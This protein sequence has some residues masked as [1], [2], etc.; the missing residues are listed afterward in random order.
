MAAKRM[1][2][3]MDDVKDLAYERIPDNEK[4]TSFDQK[5]WVIEAIHAFVETV[6]M[7]RDLK[8]C[9]VKNDTDFPFI[10]SDDPAILLNRFYSQ[11]LG[12]RW[13]SF[14]VN[15]AGVMLMLPLSPVLLM[16]SYD[17]NIYTCPDIGG[18][19]VKVDKPSDVAAIN[20]LQYLKASKNLYFSNWAHAEKIK[21]DFAVVATKR[22]KQW[23]SINFAVKDAD[24]STP[25][26]DCFRV[27]HTKEER[28]ASEE[29]FL[30]LQSVMLEP[31]IWFSKIKFRHKLKYVYNRTG[32]GYKRYRR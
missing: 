12:P 14:G 29:A 32:A 21:A 18:Y 9:L 3:A 30:H 7:V 15:N 11:R 20:M 13:K 2:V 31:D 26:S 19:V 17:Q 10:T 28:V 8:V 22:P 25:E 24:R 5:E 23:H 27:V 1:A 4:P 16:A 6:D